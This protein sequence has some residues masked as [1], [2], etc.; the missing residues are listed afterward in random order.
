MLHWI[1]T[2]RTAFGWLFGLSLVAFVATLVV[3]PIVV[4]RM[5]PDYFVADRPAASSWR[6]RHGAMRLAGR[7]AKNALGVFF[8]LTGIAMLVLPGQGIL[9]M[10][11]GLTL[12]DFPRKRG[13]E[14]WVI[15]CRPISGLINRL[16][17]RAGH[18]P[19]IVPD[20]PVTDRA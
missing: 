8:L 10:L 7:I 1:A 18:P 6:G 16:R 17:A 20:E 4:I 5:A 9:T 12:L 11:I 19:L 15:R 2:Y 3:I 13:L 14:R